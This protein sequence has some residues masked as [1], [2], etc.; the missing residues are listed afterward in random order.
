MPSDLESLIAEANASGWRVILEQQRSNW[1]A[2]LIKPA[3]T[4]EHGIV[5]LLSVRGGSDPF[6]ALAL[7]LNNSEDVERLVPSG[8][9]A[10]PSI[11]P[12][13]LLNLLNL[14][15]ALKPTTTSL[16]RI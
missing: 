2:K 11:E 14:R 15:P 13:S 10:P 3:E 6:E 16:R 9:Q 12:N 7:A 4:I 8:A 5:N 1:L